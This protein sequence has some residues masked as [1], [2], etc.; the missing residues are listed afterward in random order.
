[1]RVVGP[2]TA[3]KARD[4]ETYY[5]NELRDPLLL[6][7]QPRDGSLADLIGNTTPVSFWL[8]Q[9]DNDW[10]QA[11]TEWQKVMA[12]WTA[13]ELKERLLKAEDALSGGVKMSDIEAKFDTVDEK[14]KEVT[15]TLNEEAVYKP[16]SLA[17]VVPS[18][19]F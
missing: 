5:A 17:K 3:A 16:A 10:T 1:M 19:P 8:L 2:L 4:F 14:R 6:K 13:G 11:N 9:I 18:L 12:K 7:L 15:K